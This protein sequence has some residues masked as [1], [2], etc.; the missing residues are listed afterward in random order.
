[1]KILVE[2]AVIEQALEALE[3]AGGYSNGHGR[4]FRQSAASVE[5]ITALREALAKPCVNGCDTSNGRCVDCP[6]SVS[7]Q[8]EQEP[9]VERFEKMHANGDVWITTLAAAAIARNAAT[10]QAEREPLMI[11]P[12]GGAFPFAVVGEIEQVEQ[13]SVATVAINNWGEFKVIRVALP[14]GKHDLYAAP[15]RTKDLI[16]GEKFLLIEAYETQKHKW[17]A[18]DFIDAAI[19]ADREKNRG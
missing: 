19:A 17:T 8:A 1:M 10:Q 11:T 18:M 6:D 7:E 3:F 9:V 16:D 14:E 4:S 15:V 5:A 2:K 13:E 12:G